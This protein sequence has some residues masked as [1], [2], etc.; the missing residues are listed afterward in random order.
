MV[1]TILE[2]A[3]KV[4]TNPVEFYR[5]MPKSGG[6]VEPILFVV[7]MAGIGAI[8]MT[9]LSFVGLGAIGTMA[10]GIGAIILMPIFALIGSFIGSAILF[11]IWKLMGSQES[12]EVAYRCAA[13]ASAIYPIAMLAGLI[14]YLG[15]IV[16]IAWGMYLMIIATTEV[17]QLKTKAAAVVFG[18]IGLIFIA[19][20]LS[21]EMAARHM[22]AE[23]EHVGAQLEDLK[24]MEPEEAGKV[25]GEFLKGLENARKGI[26]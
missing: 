3:K 19:M 10:V 13:Y 8:L 9:A 5:H 1:H 14:P 12:F 24:D 25:V 6:F 20:N 26:K 23:F 18:G 11:V 16:G 22:A 7:V 4:I 21:S 17:H 15:S 2:Q